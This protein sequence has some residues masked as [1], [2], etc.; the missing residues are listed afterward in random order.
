MLQVEHGHRLLCLTHLVYRYFFN[1]TRISSKIYRSRRNRTVLIFFLTRTRGGHESRCLVICIQNRSYIW[2]AFTRLKNTRL[3]IDRWMFS[4]EN[5]V[6][7]CKY[8]KYYPNT[9]FKIVI[10]FYAIVPKCLQWPTSSFTT[11]DLRGAYSKYKVHT[12]YIYTCITKKFNKKVYFK[13]YGIIVI[14]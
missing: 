6:K 9:H 11:I 14:R 5:N 12:L 10:L 13:Y 2:A 3:K 1:L 4:F 8:S 7:N